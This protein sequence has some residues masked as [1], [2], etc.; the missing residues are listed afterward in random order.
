MNYEPLIMRALRNALGHFVLDKIHGF[1]GIQVYPRDNKVVLTSAGGT[2][3]AIS[4]ERLN[5][6]PPE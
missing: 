2:R 4:V 5:T 1:D 3:Y 6:P